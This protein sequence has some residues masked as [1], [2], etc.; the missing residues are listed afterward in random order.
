MSGMRRNMP[1]SVDQYCDLVAHTEDGYQMHHHPQYPGHEVS[2]CNPPMSATARLRPTVA[3]VPLSFIA[4]F[5]LLS[6]I[7]IACQTVLAC[8]MAVCASCG[9][10]SGKFRINTGHDGYISYRIYV[11]QSFDLIHAVH[12]E[13]VA[14]CRVLALADEFE[15]TSGHPGSPYHHA[16]L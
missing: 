13:P 1:I 12:N 10:P 14:L 4:E 9:C 6:I 7:E 3:I 2:A 5:L 16:C 8:C 15:R 11:L